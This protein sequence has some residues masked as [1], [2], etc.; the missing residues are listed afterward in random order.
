[1]KKQIEN[2]VRFRNPNFKISEN[3]TSLMLFEFV[4]IQVVGM[5]RSLTL[6]FF[7]RNPKGMIRGKSTSFKY[8]SKISWGKFLKLGDYVELNALSINGLI[9]GN[10]VSIGS[11]SRVIVS[12]TL[13]Q[14][15]DKI[16]LGNNVGIG[17]FAYLGGAGGL[18]IGNDCIVGQYF[19]C[20]PENHCTN[21][22]NTLIRFQGVA[23]KGIKIGNDCWIGAKVTILDGVNIGNKT[24]IAAGSVVTKSFPDNVI[25]A[26]IPAKIMK[27]RDELV[28]SYNENLKISLSA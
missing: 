14:L 18:E 12:T 2:I 13:N 11:F 17:E 24:I 1:M 25:I 8:L 27:H 16:Q 15:G 7:L 5:L 26:G 28:N 9:L 3:L 4:A 19:S 21:E 20:H 10:N 22:L 23:R 6:C